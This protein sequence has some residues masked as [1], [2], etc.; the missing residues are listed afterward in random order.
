MAAGSPVAVGNLPCLSRSTLPANS[1]TWR[2]K[3][4]V[5]SSFLLSMPPTGALTAAGSPIA[6]GEQPYSI[7][8]RPFRQVRLCGE[9]WF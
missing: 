6:A 1:P 8:D 7:G 5:M 9:F 4:L 3:V 2:M